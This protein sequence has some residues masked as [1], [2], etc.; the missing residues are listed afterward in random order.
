MVLSKLQCSKV[1]RGHA[2]Y[3]KGV[4]STLLV[5]LMLAVA[6]VGCRPQPAAKLVGVWVPDDTS[7]VGTVLAKG[8]LH[9]E[10][11]TDGR[12]IASAKLPVV[13]NIAKQGR[14]RYKNVEG[15]RVTIEFQ[16]EGEDKWHPLDVALVGED[17]L[18]F[19]PPLGGVKKP[20]RFA[21]QQVP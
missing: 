16:W 20:I 8:S 10:F 2:L 9:I 3:G 13:G 11:A 5:G 18:E 12:M 6:T 1:A 15:N 7:V 14:W 21:R 17:G 4:R 19:T